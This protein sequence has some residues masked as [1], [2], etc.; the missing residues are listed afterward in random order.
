MPDKDYLEGI[1]DWLR[2]KHPE[3]EQI[4]Q[5]LDEHRNGEE[6]TVRC[7]KCGKVLVVEDVWAGPKKLSTWV[8]CG[9]PKCTFMH[10]KY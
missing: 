9:T 6:I 8:L 10:L 5:A 4:L 2:E 7:P 3:I 1:P